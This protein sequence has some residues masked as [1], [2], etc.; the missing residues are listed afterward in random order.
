MKEIA[1]RLN[2]DG[3]IVLPAHVMQELRIKVGDV[4]VLKYEKDQI[5]VVSAFRVKNEG[6]EISE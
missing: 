4:L 6:K 1:I 3:R 5:Q 2:K